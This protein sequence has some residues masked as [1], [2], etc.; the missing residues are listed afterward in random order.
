MVSITNR[1]KKES[2]KRINNFF[3]RKLAG[4]FVKRHSTLAHSS[5]LR[6]LPLLPAR[7]PAMAINGA[8]MPA[9]ANTH[10]AI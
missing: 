8:R 4:L 1:L 9:P 6:L 7:L 5:D 2:N 10:Q 3:R